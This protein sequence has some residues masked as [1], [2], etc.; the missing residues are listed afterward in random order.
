[1]QYL[2]QNV[3]PILGLN[4]NNTPNW[5][6]KSVIQKLINSKSFIFIPVYISKRIVST[7]PPFRPFQLL[8]ISQPCSIKHPIPSISGNQFVATPAKLS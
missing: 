2:E 6:T 5:Q 7:F 3:L 8:K 4:E 1:M